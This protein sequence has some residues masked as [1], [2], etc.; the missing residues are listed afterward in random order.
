MCSLVEVLS[1]D[2]TCAVFAVGLG[3]VSLTVCC[4]VGA[5]DAPAL[6]DALRT[7]DP[8][9]LGRLFNLRIEECGPVTVLEQPEAGFIGCYNECSFRA[10]VATSLWHKALGEMRD[11]VAAPR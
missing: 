8:G 2:S 1:R 4:A 11:A 6:L 7:R 9:A 3:A 5:P 10:T